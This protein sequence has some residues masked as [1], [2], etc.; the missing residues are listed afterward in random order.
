M[1]YSGTIKAA[2]IVAGPTLT[3]FQVNASGNIL[4]KVGPSTATVAASFPDLSHPVSLGNLVG[5]G[6]TE[7][8]QNPDAFQLLN[9]WLYTYLMGTPPPPTLVSSVSDTNAITIT[10]TNP[11]QK[12]VAFSSYLFPVISSV[13]MDI[14]RTSLNASGLFTDASTVTV[15]LETVT[16]S[17]TVTSAIIYLDNTKTNTLTAGVYKFYKQSTFNILTEVAYDFRIYATNLNSGSAY[18]YLVVSNIATAGVG[19]P[20]VPLNPSATPVSYA[21]INTSWTVP[22]D[23][24]VVTLGLQTSTPYIIQYRVA[25]T[26]TSSIRYGGVI[27]DTGNT[28]TTTSSG[29]DVTPTL[30]VTSL[31]PGTLYTFYVYALNSVNPSFG[32]ASASFNA[33][34]NFPSGS[35]LP[36]YLT[37]GACSTLQ[38]ISTLRGTYQSA[39]TSFSSLSGTTITGTTT[40]VIDYTLM[41]N[42]NSMTVTASNIRTNFSESS[43][44]ETIGTASAYGGL[45]SD[46]TSATNVASKTVGGFGQTAAN[47]SYDS[48]S[49]ST[50]LVVANDRDF[51]SSNA[52]NLQ[53]FYKS[54]DI[55]AQAYDVA[56][57][58]VPSQ[59]MYSLAVSY[60]PVSGSNVTTTACSFYID[61]LHAT[62]VVSNPAIISSSSSNVTV[63][64]GVPTFKNNSTFTFQ[65]N[66]TQLAHYFLRNDKKHSDVILTTSGGTTIS[67]STVSITQASMS[68]ANRYYVAPASN[69]YTTSSTVHDTG[70]L[71]TA[72]S[73]PDEVQFNS[74]S[75]TLNGS[76]TIYDEG[77]LVKVIPYNLYS[78]GTQQSGAYVS[79][80]T[81][82]SQ[83]IRL[84]AKSIAAD[85]TAVTPST[86]ARQVTS[87][88]GTYPAISSGNAGQD[89]SHSTSLLTNSE[90]QLVNGIYI[91]PAY[92]AANSNI[93]YKNYTSL[94]HYI[95]GASY[96]LYDYTS[97]TSDSSY[98]YVTFKFA[99]IS[100]SNYERLQLSIV[101]TGL[102]VNFSS[103]NAA[104]HTLQVRTTG[105][106]IQTAGWLDATNAVSG[107]GVQSGENGTYAADG[108][109]TASTRYVY[110]LAGS[111]SSTI[112]YVRIGIP[113]NVNAS[114]TS[115]TCTARTSFP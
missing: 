81:G 16:T 42:A 43:T 68:G 54:C 56:T 51:N 69:K 24:D 14:V 6:V 100:S 62:P 11:P 10:W 3:E 95:A 52:T 20:D 31:N 37:T 46:Y 26:A 67:S 75:I 18:N 109:S 94:N 90:L 33:T 8:T 27:T 9:R 97:I 113:N 25:R 114:V 4:H 7:S 30:S 70:Y 48:T 63:I 99:P 47:G 36:A 2:K 93:G 13:K 101:H 55:Y 87:S 88:S 98:R 41:T 85:I 115:V 86:A 39:S 91:T 82:V 40:P 45:N 61:D 104:N 22:G 80:S 49:G 77:L 111:D 71:L 58:F 38:N 102:T 12:S 96:P 76:T 59:N 64:S 5:T 35:F 28:L 72:S 112:V 107:L 65:F 106:S 105:N 110:I 74:F 32:A 34:T 78:V 44:L 79:P 89:Y 19:V 17:P 108:I 53:G 50:R 1:S 60:A 84:D 29:A 92:S 103:F 21:Q 15:T 23:R 66:Q 57:K 83:P 73:T